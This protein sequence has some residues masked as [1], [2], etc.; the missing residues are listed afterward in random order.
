MSRAELLKHSPIMGTL[1]FHEACQ[2]VIRAASQAKP[3][4]LIQYAASYAKRG[5]QMRDMHEIKVQALYILNNLSAWRGDEARI[6]KATL[7]GFTK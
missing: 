6:V 5:M 4:A 2:R 1:A 7:K 3:D